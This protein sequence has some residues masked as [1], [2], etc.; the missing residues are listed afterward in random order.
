MQT[1]TLAE[2]LLAGMGCVE[3]PSP[4][5]LMR[6]S[7]AWVCSRRPHT[8]GYRIPNEPVRKMQTETEWAML[9]P[10]KDPGLLPLKARIRSWVTKGKGRINN[11]ERISCICLVPQFTKFFPICDL[12]G[13]TNLMRKVLHFSDEGH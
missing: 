4:R 8:G 9:P 12:I 5:W 7:V 1:Y 10:M 2:S 13:C 3:P 6:E 11:V